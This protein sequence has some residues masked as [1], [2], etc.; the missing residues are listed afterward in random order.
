MLQDPLLARGI[1][2]WFDFLCADLA[3]SRRC[4]VKLAAAASFAPNSYST[5]VRTQ[6]L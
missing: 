4:L 6:A 5:H 3:V 2:A 1:F